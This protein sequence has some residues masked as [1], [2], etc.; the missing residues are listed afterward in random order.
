MRMRDIKEGE[1]PF[2][3][4]DGVGFKLAG[5]VA[6]DVVGGDINAA[7]APTTAAVEHQ[8]ERFGEWQTK[9]LLVSLKLVIFI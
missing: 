5:V 6:Y 4:T 9:V 7:A 1:L 8:Q 3:T 2:K